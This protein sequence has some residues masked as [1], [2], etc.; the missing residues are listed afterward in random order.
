MAKAKQGTL[1]VE[2]EQ[3]E[4]KELTP[5]QIRE[6]AAKQKAERRKEKEWL[7]DEVEHL[8]LLAKYYNL[9]LMVPKLAGDFMKMQEE[10]ARR[11][12]QIEKEGEKEEEESKII[13]PES[14]IVDL[15][16]REL[17]ISK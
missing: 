15:E 14:K 1:E 10:K 6:I 8:E 5:A 11:I 4:T 2:A 9:S 3:M 7:K 17:K 16:G 12:E 13:K